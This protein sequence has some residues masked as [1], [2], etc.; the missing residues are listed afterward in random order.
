MYTLTSH[1][2][3]FMRTLPILFLPYGLCAVL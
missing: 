2:V 1:N 3:T